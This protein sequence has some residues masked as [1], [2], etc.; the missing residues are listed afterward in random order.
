MPI[1]EI[2]TK[3]N[4]QMEKIIK[5]SLESVQLNIPGTAYF[6]PY[7]GQLTEFYQTQVNAKYWVAVNELDEVIGGVGIGPF[8][9]HKGVS[10]LQKLYLAAEAQGKGIAK[11][12]MK[13]AL[14]FAE[15]HYDLCYLETFDSLH[16]A[17]QLYIKFGFEQLKQPLSGSEH[18]ACDSW[19]MK[20]L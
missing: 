19:Y 13:T 9:N 4:K 2:E 8:G 10:E 17:N 7:L 16:A 20:K 12:L 18:S 3:D 6:D 5:H 14:T 15:A 1:R 11:E